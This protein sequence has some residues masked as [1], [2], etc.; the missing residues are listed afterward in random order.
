MRNRPQI[1]RKSYFL[2]APNPIAFFTRFREHFGTILGSFGGH[3]GRSWGPLAPILASWVASEPPKWPTRTVHERCKWPPSY[4]LTDFGASGPPR[5]SILY[6]FG[7]ISGQNRT[8]A[9]VLARF[10]LQNRA[11]A[12]V[13][14]RFHLQNRAHVRVSALFDIQQWQER[15]IDFDFSGAIVLKRHSDFDFRKILTKIVQNRDPFASR[16]PSGSG[17]RKALQKC[18]LRGPVSY[19]HLTLPTN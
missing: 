2:R 13:L 3:F 1:D 8:H 10:H 11:H 18:A 7:L 6:D 14:A 12:R 15:R 9:R 5:T 4:H 16:S 19:T 17:L